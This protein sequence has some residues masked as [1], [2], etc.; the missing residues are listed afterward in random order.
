MCKQRSTVCKAAAPDVGMT[1]NAS[2]TKV[3][4]SRV[5]SINWQPLT[6]DGVSQKDVQS[7]VYLGST[8]IPSEQAAA[9]IERRIG[10]T[11]SVFVRLKRSLWGRRET[12]TA[13]KGR[14]Y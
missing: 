5:D 10:A 12:S 11:R 3:M 13:T 4:S 6:L 14:I 7:F 1:I 8:I 2:K 9:E